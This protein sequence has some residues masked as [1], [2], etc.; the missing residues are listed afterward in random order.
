[1]KI[2]TTPSVVIRIV[3]W[4]FLIVGGAI[5]SISKDLN[6]SYF[7]SISF[8]IITFILGVILMRFAFRAAATG[9]K[10]LAQKGRE[11]NLPRLETNKLVTTGIY[12]CT[13]HPMLFG[14]TLIPISIALILGS[15]T[16]ITIVA[17]I[18]MIFIIVMVLTMEEK[19]CKIKYGDE[20]IKYSQ[21]VPLF[22]KTKEC[23]KR[24]FL[25]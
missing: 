22:P 7:N 6:S 11:G 18:E 5:Y 25:E 16:F 20:Y 14:L 12:S 23:F 1:M 2:S 17:P 4:L 21:K 13:R 8:H 10:E 9:G 19:E 24:L 15:P 3:L